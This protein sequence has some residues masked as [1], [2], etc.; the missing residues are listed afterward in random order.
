MFS[1]K[2]YIFILVWI[3]SIL[4]T[5]IWVFENSDKIQSIKNILKTNKVK[6][7]NIG[8][9]KRVNSAAGKFF[10]PIEYKIKPKHTKVPCTANKP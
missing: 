1:K 2:I 7:E 8:K 3:I 4:I 5:V 10:D 6:I 9:D